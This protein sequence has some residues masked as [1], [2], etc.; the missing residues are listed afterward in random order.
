MMANNLRQRPMSDA[1]IHAYVDGQLKQERS[2]GLQS[3]LGDRPEKYEQLEEY[4]RINEGLRS[5]LNFILEEPIPNSILSVF[6]S[7]AAAAAPEPAPAGKPGR[8]ASPEKAAVAKSSAAK[9]GKK[10]RQE[11]PSLDPQLEEEMV[12]KTGQLHRIA[13]SIR[14][15]PVIVIISILF[16]V[17]G[18]NVRNNF[19][20]QE[21]KV[22]HF[23][24]QALNSAHIFS[25]TTPEL[26][27]RRSLDRLFRK[28]FTHPLNIPNSREINLKGGR[29]LPYGD[30]SVAGMM[31]YRVSGKS[32]TLFFNQDQGIVSVERPYCEIVNPK[33]VCYWH[34]SGMNFAL[35]STL[36]EGQLRAVAKTFVQKLLRDPEKP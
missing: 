15:V 18:W 12:Y 32:V 31:L 9:P 33:T 30:S 3:I 29:I 13:Q 27:D 6:D 20:F 8:R 34:R 10:S 16:F 5:T 23:V 21:E 26:T 2:Q 36:D 1:H 14:M 24:N 28:K 35:L 22:A 19:H 25:D 4:Q 7:A 11:Q 17:A